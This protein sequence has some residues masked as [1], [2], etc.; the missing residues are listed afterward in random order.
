MTQFNMVESPKGPDPKHLLLAV[1]ATSAVFMIYSYFFS[2]RPI[3]PDAKIEPNAHI[4]EVLPTDN[5][6]ELPLPAHNESTKHLALIKQ[7]F[8]SIAKTDVQKAARTSYHAEISNYG[9]MIDRFVLVDFNEDQVLFD[10]EKFGSSL[11]NLS[12]QSPG[13]LLKDHV[14]YQI[15]S[16]DKSHITLR[17]VTKEGL[18]VKRQYQFCEKAVIKEEITWK[19]LSQIPLKVEPVLN[20]HKKDE[21]GEQSG[22]FNPGV[23]GQS[24]A[25]RSHEKYER[26]AY[27]DLMNKPKVFT[28][29]KYV[30][31]D[32]QFFLSAIIPGSDFIDA[33]D[34]VNVV[35]HEASDKK[36]DAHIELTL[37][38]FFLIAGEQKSLSH[39]FFIG[40]KQVDLL[41]SFS[42]PLDENIDFGW[43]GVLSRPMLWLLVQI[44]GFVKNYGLA[45]ILITFIIK[46]LTYPL[47]QKS[48]TSQQE[49]K[50]LQPKIKEL[51]QKFGH[52]RTLLGQKQMELYRT[53]GIN[54]VAGC[55][56]LLIQLPI[57][58]AF[59]QMLRN[60]V[61]LFDQPFYWWITDLTRPDHYF[62]LPLLMGVS[63][64][65]QQAFTPPPVDQ[66][67]MK[68]VMWAMPVFLTFI[69]LNMPSGLS[70][71][72]LT[73]NLLT[74]GQQIIIKRNP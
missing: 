45:I 3:V 57:W 35:V 5:G 53:H 33:I 17:H 49:M 56:P 24:I 28:K 1:L 2:E 27:A 20:A 37:K 44:Y 61:E 41:S 64:L 23:Q 22:F 59:F 14:P 69:M 13:G 34:H 39:Q 65:I 58:F 26:I 18:E 25:V 52:D 32:D 46:L 38:P 62:V 66:P 4:K 30:A 48:F 11:L 70:L 16:S 8:E 12:S 73:N 29:I 72:I 19:N 10:E 40:P 60:S 15:E 67:H 36:R 43:F 7:S 9:G 50:K 42:V 68:Y 54:P 47:T 63:M 74:I 31:F 55:L 6:I 71:Y 51:Q 21:T